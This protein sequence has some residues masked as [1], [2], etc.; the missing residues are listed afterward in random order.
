[1][2]RAPTLKGEIAKGLSLASRIDAEI[3]SQLKQ[4]HD[5]YHFPEGSE[6]EWEPGPNELSPF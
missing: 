4:L 2:P 3:S 1:M 5:F 6:V